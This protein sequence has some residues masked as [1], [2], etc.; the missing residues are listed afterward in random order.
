MLKL[1]FP[2]DEKLETGSQL[3]E[4]AASVFFFFFGGAVPNA[5]AG[6]AEPRRFSWFTGIS[7]AG[8]IA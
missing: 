7:P 2:L 1:Y 6:Q 8:R 3:T 5:A 4:L